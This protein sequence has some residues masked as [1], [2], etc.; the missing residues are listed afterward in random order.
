MN[1]LKLITLAATISVSSAFAGTVFQDNFNTE[2]GGNGQ[3]NYTGLAQWTVDRDSIDLIGPGFWDLYPG[4]GMYLDMDGS[5]GGSGNGKITTKMAFGAGSYT[6]MFDLGNNPGGGSSINSLTVTLGNWSETF[7]TTGYPALTT[8]TRNFSTTGGNLVF[9]Q[10]GPSDQ[11][12]T[13]LDNVSLGTS[14]V[15]NVATP[16]PGSLLLAAS[17]AVTALVLR[18]R[19]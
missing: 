19:S 7:L 11:Q 1:K 13:I 8:I 5:T 6:L 16:E 17:A 4:N 3:L 14:G 2:N 10:G 9:E 18:R 12:G 15:Q